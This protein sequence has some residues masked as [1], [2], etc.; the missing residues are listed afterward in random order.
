MLN[1][2]LHEKNEN[3][4]VWGVVFL[5]SRKICPCSSDTLKRE[6]GIKEE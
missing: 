5:K 1:L 3:D 6:R 4:I 2:A